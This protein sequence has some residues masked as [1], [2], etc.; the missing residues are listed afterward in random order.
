MSC[1]AALET[2]KI[3]EE[4]GLIENAA[5]MGKYVE[6]QVEAMKGKHPSIGNFRT[7]GL[8]GCIE[9]VKNRNTKEPM[10]PFN[11]K[12]D[13]ML[14]MNK[15]A[16]KISELGM[17]TFVRW[18]YIYIAPP[19]FVTKEQIDEGLAIISEAIAIADEHILN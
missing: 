9:L 7:T 6:Q 12:P 13:E 19:L 18:S 2:L 8:L 14:V 11:A 17:Y 1:A 4:E 5:A 16:A 10:A 3:Y 15:V